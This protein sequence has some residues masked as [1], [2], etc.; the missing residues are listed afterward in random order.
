MVAQRNMLAQLSGFMVGNIS[1]QYLGFPIFNGKPKC[2]HFQPI[3]DR[4]NVKLATWKGV[5][6][7]IMGRI[8]LVK[9]I[10]HGMLVYSFHIY[11]WH[12]R[13]LKML[14][15]VWSGDIYTRKIS[16]ISWYQ[17]CLP[18]DVG[19]LDLKSTRSINES[20]LLHLSW[21]LFTQTSQCSRLFQER[22]LSFGLPRSRYFKSS[23]WP[24][25]KVHLTTV[26]A[27]SCKFFDFF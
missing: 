16:T 7:S 25:V 24:G 27:N 12:V 15:M 17:V 3:L 2:I 23:I 22:F 1:F 26:S 5:L 4:I 10:V 21:K 18:W 20:F 19:G 14:D 11:R 8:Q 13:L 9:S 6:L